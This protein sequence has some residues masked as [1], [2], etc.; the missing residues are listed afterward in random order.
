MNKH[1]DIDL[2]TILV[3]TDH[4]LKMRRLDNQ[5]GGRL[6]PIVGFGAYSLW[7]LKNGKRSIRKGLKK[8]RTGIS[9]IL[10]HFENYKIIYG[11][12]LDTSDFPRRSHRQDVEGMIS[13]F[14]DLFIP[15]FNKKEEGDKSGMGF[16]E[17]IKQVLW[18]TE[19]EQRYLGNPTPHSWKA[20]NKS[21]N[22]PDHIVHLT[23]NYRKHPTKDKKLRGDY[24]KK[25]NNYLLKLKELIE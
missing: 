14:R 10:K 4:L 6:D 15:S 5:Y 2:V 17:V 19:N 9:R 13:V 21:I 24:M 16:Q 7:E 25:L 20:L 1:S 23:Y 8:N 22:D 18:L 11:E 3:S 12:P